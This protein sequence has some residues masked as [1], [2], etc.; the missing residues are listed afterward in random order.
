MREKWSCRACEKITQPPAPFHVIARGRAGASLLAMIL[1]GKFA[2]HL[3]LTRQAETYAR[4]GVEIDV[5]TMADWVGPARQR[6]IRWW[7]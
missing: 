1:A 3:P 4:E 7:R 2:Q 6:F 5:S